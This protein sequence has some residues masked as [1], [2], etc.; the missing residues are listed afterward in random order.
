MK[1]TVHYLIAVLATG[2]AMG[3][4]MSLGHS[5]MFN[6]IAGI[7]FWAFMWLPMLGD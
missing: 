1:K 5:I 6:I 7:G 3:L 2:T 4:L